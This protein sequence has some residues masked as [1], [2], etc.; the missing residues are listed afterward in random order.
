[1][2]LKV[3]YSK[4]TLNEQEETVA[5]DDIKVHKKYFRRGNKT[6]KSGLGKPW[7]ASR[8]IKPRARYGPNKRRLQLFGVPVQ[9][10]THITRDFYIALKKAENDYKANHPEEYKEYVKVMRHLK[11]TPIKYGWRTNKKTGKKYWGRKGWFWNSKRDGWGGA[12]VSKISF[13]RYRRRGDK[14]TEHKFDERGYDGKGWRV[15]SGGFLVAATGHHNMSGTEIDWTYAGSKSGSNIALPIP[16]NLQKLFNKYRISSSGLKDPGHQHHMNFYNPKEYSNKRVAHALKKQYHVKRVKMYDVD[17]IKTV[18]RIA[19]TSVTTSPLPAGPGADATT[20]QTSH[21]GHEHG[22]QTYTDESGKFVHGFS[23]EEHGKD[24]KFKKFYED[25]DTYFGKDHKL[26]TDWG[27]DYKFGREHKAAYDALQK[28]KAEGPPP[29]AAAGVDPYTDPRTEGTG[30]R[31]ART[32][33]DAAQMQSAHGGEEYFPTELL[34]DL[35]VS[36]DLADTY[37][38]QLKLQALGVEPIVDVTK[39]IVDPDVVPSE[40]TDAP[41]QQTG[42]PKSALQTALMKTFQGSSPLGPFTKGAASPDL[43]LGQ[44]HNVLSAN[45]AVTKKLA[46]WLGLPGR[47]ALY[48][49]QQSNAHLEKIIHEEYI[50]LLK[51]THR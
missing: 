14:H 28:R 1:M 26:L 45:Q 13:P 21:E 4:R 46:Q 42:D 5:Y 15:T 37:Q 51:E 19:P 7:T 48:Q 18:D 6:W 16:T 36:P 8:R 47:G 20:P 50:K 33:A 17:G 32:P 43:P 12:D 40:P 2:K 41:V 10:A 9:N 3:R 44:P 22:P 23:R 30:F 29:A 11:A 24:F 39:P 49:E 25:L 27:K 34:P 35:P 31:V 38:N